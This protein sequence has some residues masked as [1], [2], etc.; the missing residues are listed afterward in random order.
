MA[1]DP[2]NTSAYRT[3]A[4]DV[5]EP[6]PYERLARFPVPGLGSF[7][8]GL[9]LGAPLRLGLDRQAL[10]IT[11]GSGLILRASA[12][13]L[14][15][16]ELRHLSLDLTTAT[17]DL[18]SPGLG[19][20][21]SR[22]ATLAATA[23]FQEVLPW[24]PGRSLIDAAVQ[25]LPTAA[26]GA[27]RIF[28]R[29][30]ASV[31]IDPD[32]RLD[33]TVTADA[34]EVDLSHPVWLRVFG[35]AFGLVAVRYLFDRQRIELQ[36]PHGHGLRNLLL[37]TV[38]W[39]AT[40]WLRKRLPAALA[41]PG[42][43][44]VA[45][46]QRRA[47]MLALIENLKGKPDPKA[48]KPAPAPSDSQPADPNSPAARLRKLADMRFTAD[49]VPADARMLV[50]IP[51]GDRG[52]LAVCTD[53]AGDVLLR[54]RAARI[55]FE[56][57]AGLYVHADNLSQ[58]AEL[59]VVRVALQTD[60]LAAELET[61]PPL[62]S[63]LQAV[64]H[65]IARA[66]LPVR[67]SPAVLQRLAALRSDDILFSQ[68]FGD[69]GAGVTLATPHSHEITLRHGHDALELKIP[70]GLQLTWQQLDFLPDAEI[71]GLR[72]VWATG[73]LSLD[74]TPELGEFGDRFVSQMLRYRAA[75]HLPKLL[76][77]RGPDSGTPV[78][79]AVALAHP[80]VIY[81][82]TLP[83]V[84]PL[85]VRIDPA[86]PLTISLSVTALDIN[87]DAGVVILVPELELDLVFHNF[88]YEPRAR[89]IGGSAPLGAYITEVLARLLESKALP[90]MR[91]RL[92]GW[93]DAEADRPWRIAAF[94]AGPLGEVRVELPAGA[95][96]VA[97][98]TADALTLAIRDPAHPLATISIVPQNQRFAPALGF[99]RIRWRPHH[100]EWTLTLS[101]PTGPLV[102]DL[103]KR[104][105]HKFVPLTVLTQVAGYLALPTPKRI[106]PPSV[107]PPAPG[108]VLFETTIPQLGALKVA[109]D[110]N[111]TVDVVLQRGAAAISFGAGVA[112]R[113]PALGF[114]MQLTGLQ[115]TLH[116]FHVNLDSK[117]DAGPLPDVL[118]THAAKG[119]LGDAAAR[120]SGTAQVGQ[121]NL[122]VFGEDKPWGPLRIHVPTDGSV[123][124]HLD[125]TLLRLSSQQGVFISG[126]SIDWLPD[127]QL[128][129]FQYTFETGAVLLEISGI[130]ENFYHEAHPVSPVTQAL[131]AHLIK[132]LALPKLPPAARHLGLR[133]FPIP[134][135]PAVPPKHV[136]LYRVQLPGEYGEV[137]ISMAPEDAVT[138]RASEEEI[139][140]V[141]DRGVMATLAGLRFQLSLRGVRYH[142]QS[143]EIQIGGLGQLENAVIEAIVARQLRG[144]PQIAGE[145]PDD[146][147]PHLGS[148]LEQLPVDDKGR[149]VLFAHKMVNILLLPGA[150]LIIRFTAEGLDFAADPPI[151]IDGPVRVDYKFDGIRYSFPDGSFHLAV[152]NAGGLFAGI[153]KDVAIPRVEAKLNDFLKPLL[154]PAMRVPGYS[155]A[156]DPLSTEHVKQIVA[157]FGDLK[158]K[159]K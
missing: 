121:D 10:R 96:I 66:M 156:N 125:R 128:H 102:H 117:P 112:V 106:P 1:E 57:P 109:A 101:P 35:L 77:L 143:G 108:P 140:V 12:S 120:L 123:A 152:E 138:V 17:V 154:P 9:G 80:A 54:R 13:S 11:P 44:P 146:M 142:L 88:R 21:E 90:L 86:D 5:P 105:V 56:A 107:P 84:G 141:S 139:S 114:N 22:A 2:P 135:P 71:R 72:Y 70:G 74:A 62:G 27:R 97:E 64:V 68:K 75:A 37:R 92:P 134:A 147:T 89:G 59:R 137:F 29:G 113:L 4:A 48:S 28:A 42:Y 111:R 133:S 63:F 3:P 50:A 23:V 91:T 82:T 127:F 46:P 38:A 99:Q 122:L 36:G 116:P 158:R 148:L 87:S 155:L 49:A 159:K 6:A 45:D 58:L 144:V 51:L 79:P 40:K 26:D 55:A 30:P 73:E 119:G 83:A 18:G 110:P 33:L 32:A 131:L 132:V 8:L 61:S 14:P 153:L 25:N 103:I 118:L 104:L 157:N 124:V 52:K 39:I 129:A 67:V 150:T 93:N 15:P 31:W 20:F 136:G 24:Q 98:R 95:A 94:P 47:H 81:E 53:R 7:D 100:D 41:T 85:I 115:G 76:G 65:H 19:A 149:I 145:T 78:D 16:L 34:L 60:T 43:D 69:S 130:Q 151:F 126:R